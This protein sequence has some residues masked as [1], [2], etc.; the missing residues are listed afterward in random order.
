MDLLGRSLFLAVFDFP[1][2]RLSSSVSVI[3]PPDDLI[4]LTSVYFNSRT[5]KH[6]L[7]RANKEIVQALLTTQSLTLN[8]SARL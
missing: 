8:N 2:L 5:G 7:K 6:F 1:S 3:V 4:R